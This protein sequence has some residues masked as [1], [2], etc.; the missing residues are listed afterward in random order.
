MSKKKKNCVYATI[1]LKMSQAG[2]HAMCN[3]VGNDVFCVNGDIKPLI[4]LINE[5]E[6]LNPKS[7][8]NEEEE[9]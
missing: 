9:E 4:N 1:V 6:K 5:A 8:I 2:I 7:K 3:D